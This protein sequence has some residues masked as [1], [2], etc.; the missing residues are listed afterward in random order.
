MNC[1]WL[2]CTAPLFIGAV[3][4]L[5][6]PANAATTTCHDDEYGNRTCCTQ[7]KAEV[8][9]FGKP[10]GLIVE[11]T[12]AQLERGISIDQKERR[13]LCLGSGMG[14]SQGECHTSYGRPQCADENSRREASMSPE[15]RAVLIRNAD[16]L[17]NVWNNLIKRAIKVY[18][19]ALKGGVEGSN[20]GALIKEYEKLLERGKKSA[21]DLQ[22]LLEK[23][24]QDFSAKLALAIKATSQDLDL[25]SRQLQQ[26][27][28]D[29]ASAEDGTE[30]EERADLARLRS[31]S[32]QTADTTRMSTGENCMDLSNQ[33]LT[34][35]DDTWDQGGGTVS[36]TVQN[37]CSFALRV[38]L[39]AEGAAGSVERFYL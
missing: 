33:C 4:V 20:P 10:Y 31:P 32:R 13:M 25:T 8:F 38:A 27:S 26:V 37:T 18:Q 24:H 7:W 17:L 39:W 19:K 23:T 22:R 6:F 21:Q 34:K 12:Y 9:V 16:D 28:D 36:V 11:N 35:I 5:S 30:S 14:P 1:R 29:I 2:V 3:S 15:E